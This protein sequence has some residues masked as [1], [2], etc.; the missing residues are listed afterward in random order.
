MRR[1]AKLYVS[2]LQDTLNGKVTP[3]SQTPR[4]VMKK[5]LLKKGGKKTLIPVGTGKDRGKLKKVLTNVK[6]S[7]TLEKSKKL[8]K[9]AVEK[10]KQLRNKISPKVLRKLRPRQLADDTKKKPSGDKDAT[11]EKEEIK[12]AEENDVE[13]GESEAQAQAEEP[14]EDENKPEAARRSKRNNKEPAKTIEEESDVPAEDGEARSEQNEEALT[15]GTEAAE[16]QEE[17]KSPVKERKFSKRLNRGTSNLSSETEPLQ[18]AVADTEPGQNTELQSGHGEEHN[19]EE[20]GSLE[21]S[22]T[23]MPVTEES[24]EVEEPNSNPGETGDI[25]DDKDATASKPISK[26]EEE[27][28]SLAASRAKVFDSLFSESPRKSSRLRKTVDP[29][30]KASAPVPKPK[31]PTPP[32]V[33]NVETPIAPMVSQPLLLPEIPQPE[34]EPL[35]LEPLEAAL[36]DILKKKRNYLF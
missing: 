28:D 25:A 26:L 32:E 2:R 21:K 1:K 27:I 20:E 4:K 35:V 22:E 34:P 31:E 17:G 24:M 12:P 7:P 36:P 3:V 16:A 5:K 23:T 33:N 9:K 15:P 30:P 14:T 6:P 13:S 11:G 10:S 18:S 8:I 29:K 19:T